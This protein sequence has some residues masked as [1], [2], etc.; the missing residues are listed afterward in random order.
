MGYE[1]FDLSIEGK[2]AHVRF[3][4]P[5]ERNTLTRKGF[6]ELREIVGTVDDDGAIRAMVLSSTGKGYRKVGAPVARDLCGT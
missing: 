3:N 4:R 5:D 1:C 2:V 6:R